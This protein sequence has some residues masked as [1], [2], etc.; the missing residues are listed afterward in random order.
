MSKPDHS[1]S[2]VNRK[3]QTLSDLV[4]ITMHPAFRL[5][6]LDAR[7]GRPLD[8]D[9]IMARILSETPAGALKRLRW[10]A[11]Q[12]FDGPDLFGVDSAQAKRAAKSVE[13]AQYRYEEGRKLYLEY[14]V[15][16]K[17]WGHPDFPPVAVR[18]FCVKRLQELRAGDE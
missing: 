12:L 1:D 6:F 8:H 13:V 9:T 10:S 18:E 2:L 4:A 7:A 3:A 14:G 16:C 11:R 17:A 15:R 5:G